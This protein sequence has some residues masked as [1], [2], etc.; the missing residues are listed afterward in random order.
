MI[1]ATGTSVATTTERR[2]N[3]KDIE[4]KR[5]RRW[6]WIAGLLLVWGAGC[7]QNQD[8][9]TRQ[10]RLAVAEN[11]QLRK[12]LARCEARVEALKGEY[13]KQ[14]ERR[15]AQ[16]AASRQ[17]GDDLKEDLRKGIATRV[18]AVTTK[19]MDENARLR[20]EIETLRAEIAKLKT[21]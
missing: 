2:R 8:P 7:Q 12:D 1:D 15:D 13:T 21:K 3:R 6:M 16:L 19:V 5:E 18:N 11:I 4:M 20:K 10:A 9:D 14:L 17:L